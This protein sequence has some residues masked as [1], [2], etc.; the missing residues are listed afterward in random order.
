MLEDL[1]YSVAGVLLAA[2]ALKGF[3]VPNLFLGGGITGIS[4]LLK[5]VLHVNF[6]VI[7]VLIN[8][9]FIILGGYL[10]NR[11]FAIKTLL[12][13]IG[14]AL[15]MEFIEF[16]MVTSD[17]SLISAFGGVFLGIGIGLAMRGG[18][19][20]D[21]IEIVAL[22]TIRKSGF[23][24]SEIILGLNVFIFLLAAVNFGMEIAMNSILTFYTA[25]QAIDFVVEGIEEYTGVTIIS[26]QSEAIKRTLVMDLGRGITIFKG[27]R[28]FMRES[29]D[30]SQDCDI[31]FTVITR[32]E[33]RR[34]KNL[35]YRIDPKAFVFTNTIKETAGGI[36]KRNRAEV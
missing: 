6:S 21:G 17:T 4:I 26:S 35:V 5:Q 32:L 31:V 11:R 15:C 22:I 8:L 1:G 2:Y 23:S 30:V 24:M 19:S 13:I 10:I 18:C 16:P 29:F 33:V 34:L 27:E 14:L 28:G 12:C 7:L 36:L 3:L 9:P 20:L 25:S